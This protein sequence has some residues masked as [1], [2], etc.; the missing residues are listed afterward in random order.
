[1][2]YSSGQKKNEDELFHS[3]MFMHLSGR[4]FYVDRGGER[5]L[6]GLTPGKQLTSSS[7]QEGFSKNISGYSRSERRKISQVTSP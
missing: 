3:V 1:M 6:N 7:I 2:S 4:K 5:E